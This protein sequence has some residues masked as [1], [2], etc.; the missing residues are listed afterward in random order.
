M[1][2]DEPPPALL[3]R[4][5]SQRYARPEALES[6][7]PLVGDCP[8]RMV[9]EAFIAWREQQLDEVLGITE[10]LLG[11]G[12]LGPR[13]ASRARNVQAAALLD[14]GLVEQAAT[15][16]LD[17][18]ELAKEADDAVAL[19]AATHDMGGV[20][21][22]ADPERAAQQYLEA[23]AL[24]RDFRT[25]A[26]PEDT[27]ESCAIEAV[28][29]LN[30]HDLQVG[31][32][33]PLAPDVPGLA[34]A[35][36][37]AL[38]GWPELACMI[39]AVRVLER[40][41]VGDVRGATELAA[42]LPDAASMRD[43]TIAARVVRAQ[44]RL[45]ALHG[46]HEQ[47][48]A[49]LTA[50][51]E[52]LPD[53]YQIELLGDLDRLL[54]D[55][56]HLQEALDVARHRAEVIMRCHAG[57]AR[58]AVRALEVWHRTRS[59]ERQAQEAAA[60]AASLR[61]AMDELRRHQA[62]LRELTTRD[63]LTGLSNRAH[64]WDSVE[65][66]AGPGSQLA[67]IDVDGFKGVNDS[68]GHAAGDAVLR[69]LA[70]ALRAACSPT[71]LCARYGG[72]E[73]VVLRGPDDPSDLATDLRGLTRLAAGR[74]GHEVHASIGVTRITDEGFQDALD[75]ADRL[76]YLAKR[77]GGAQIEADPR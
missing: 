3:E 16:H 76:M 25:G 77:S 65:R 42:A 36:S 7:L 35:E 51:I 13:W 71:D 19:A 45:G 62:R 63:A 44:A 37:L 22:Y 17:E 72:D 53:G 43:V 20:Y 32:G 15:A 56:G 64:L 23:I 48:R 9:F 52:R 27:R 6:G 12:L 28:A 14:L 60:Q 61:D 46:R 69:R 49:M 41:D 58:A 74:D 2:S 66:L 24:A 70:A 1:T 38:R 10:P 54:A 67:V 59:A 33:L 31:Q 18:L 4:L 39:R 21:Q 73:F 57:E 5:W 55:A 40:L 50:F 30:L 11:A 29:I 68:Q 8:E 47:G 26:S 75:R 34:A